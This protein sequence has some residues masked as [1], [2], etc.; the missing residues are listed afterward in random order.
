MAANVSTEHF[1]GLVGASYILGVPTALAQ[2]QTTIAEIVIVF[3]FVPFLI[4]AHVVTVPQYLS[5]RF[6]PGVRL[7]FALLTIFANITIFMAA[8]MYAGGLALSGFS[9]GRCLP[10]SSAPDCLPASG[11]SMAVSTPWPGLVC[12]PRSSKSAA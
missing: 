3:L 6:G 7:A 9:A 10:A 2:W 5:A 4:R 11:R 1:I 8:V 12:S